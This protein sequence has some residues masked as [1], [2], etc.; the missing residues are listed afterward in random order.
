MR[1]IGSFFHME[2]TLDSYSFIFVCVVFFLGHF[3]GVLSGTLIGALISCLVS[4][5]EK[6]Y[7]SD[8]GM[9]T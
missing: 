1:R 9:D 3:L 8:N 4:P 2:R 7:D 5:I 6:L